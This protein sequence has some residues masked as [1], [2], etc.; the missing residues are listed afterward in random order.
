LVVVEPDL[1]LYTLQA[2]LLAYSSSRDTK[3]ISSSSHTNL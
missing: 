1:Y 2:L 3:Q